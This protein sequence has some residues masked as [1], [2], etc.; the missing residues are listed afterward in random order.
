[1]SD[2]T[3]PTILITN[4]EDAVID[5]AQMEEVDSIQVEVS[6]EEA[7]ALLKDEDRSDQVARDVETPKPVAKGPEPGK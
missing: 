7:E 6:Q 2:N 4:P 3:I 1:M 5:D